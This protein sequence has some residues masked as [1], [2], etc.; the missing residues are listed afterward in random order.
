MV[1]FVFFFFLKQARYIPAHNK[2]TDI[3]QDFKRLNSNR[4][5]SSTVLVYLKEAEKKKRN[6]LREGLIQDVWFSL[7]LPP[8]VSHLNRYQYLKLKSEL[9]YRLMV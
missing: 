3:R 6:K 7:R 9:I 1:L 2:K 8:L 5:I 4:K